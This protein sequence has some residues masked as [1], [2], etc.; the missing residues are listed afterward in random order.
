MTH[1]KCGGID[2]NSFITN[3]LLI[4]EVK[5]MRRFRLHAFGFIMYLVVALLKVA[6]VNFTLNEYMIYDMRLTSHDQH[7]ANHSTNIWTLTACCKQS[8]VNTHVNNSAAVYA[9]QLS[10]CL[11]HGWI[12]QK[13]CKLESPNLHR[14]LA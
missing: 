12:S 10:I 2:S 11:S 1:L 5:I 9:R 13:R 4:L 6:L 7:P 8:T 14:R 3:C